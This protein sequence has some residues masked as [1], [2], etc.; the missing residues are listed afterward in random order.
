MAEVFRSLNLVTNHIHSFTG[1]K[2]RLEVLKS[3]TAVVAPA[4]DGRVQKS[5]TVYDDY[6]HHPTECRAS[7]QALK[8]ALPCAQ[9]WIVWE[10]ITR[11]RLEYF[12]EDFV[13]VFASAGPEAIIVGPVDV[14]REKDD[15]GKDQ[16]LFI[17]LEE[18][19]NAALPKN[20]ALL[21][22]CAIII[23][24][25]WFDVNDQLLS[26]LAKE[27]SS[28]CESNIVV[29][30]MGANKVTQAAQ[31]FADCEQISVL[32]QQSSL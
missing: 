24:D 17:G 7:L 20:V 12:L 11:S 18:R 29:I 10:P 26:L 1:T 21:N 13:E 27:L 2:R 16:Q 23:A 22:D 9:L 15:P 3:T 31:A 5:I 25:L 4:G 32:E 30:F 6:A 19:L 14:S 8:E 28:D